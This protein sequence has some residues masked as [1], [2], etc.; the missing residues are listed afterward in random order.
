MGFHTFPIER[1]E[2]LEDPGRYRYCSREELVAAVR[3]GPGGV[4]LDL[5]CGTGFFARDVAPFVEDL[6]AVDVQPAMLGHLRATDPPP[7]VHPLAADA[8]ALPLADGSV[9]VAYSTMTFHEYAS[10]TAHREVR[11]V[12]DPEGRLV[13]VDWSRTGAGED[14]PDLAERYDLDGATRMLTAAGFHV[15][16]TQERPE[17][18]LVVA[19]P[20]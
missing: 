17:T 11:R 14:G 7:D 13:T 1:A 16:H 19:R 5:G 18:Y 20:A 12:L 6:L 15:I 8:A 3:S 9:A 2:S 4:A 10:A